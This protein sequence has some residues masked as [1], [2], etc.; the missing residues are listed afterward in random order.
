MFDMSP[1]T[2]RLTVSTLLDE[3]GLSTA[4]FAEKAQLTYNQAL[5]IRRG[6][7]ERIDLNTIGRICEALS[8]EPGA[9]FKIERKAEAT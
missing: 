3:R 9:L 7:Y 4:D 1:L 5:S 6:M 8:V 2:V